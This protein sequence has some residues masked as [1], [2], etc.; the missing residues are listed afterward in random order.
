VPANEPCPAL[1]KE[2]DTVPVNI[3]AEDAMTVLYLLQH[4]GADIVY[5]TNG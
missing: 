5:E 2:I 1:E 4:V 3:D